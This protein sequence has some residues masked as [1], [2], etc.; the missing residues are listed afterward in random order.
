MIRRVFALIV[1]LSTLLLTVVANVGAAPA[2]TVTITFKDVT[3]TFADTNP[4]TGEPGLVTV[5]YNGVLHITGLPNGTY[6]VTG[7]QTGTFVFEPDDPSQPS[8]A[9][10]FT[11]WFGENSNQASFNGTVTFRVNG[12]GS[13]GSTLRFNGVAHISMSA[14]GS[15]TSFDFGRCH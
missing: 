3:E 6:H 14:T 2:E 11:I 5:T 10:R 7:T 4:C 15:T 8:V 13:D 12:Q 1:T 9:G